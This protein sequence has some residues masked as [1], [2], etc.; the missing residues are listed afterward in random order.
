LAS[1]SLLIEGS[2]SARPRLLVQG[3]VRC[4]HVVRRRR[5]R[6]RGVVEAADVIDDDAGRVVF[7]ADRLD[8][9]ARLLHL[10]F[11][12]TINP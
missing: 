12:N 4:R 3:G 10:G 8:N 5:R 1:F 9:E 6:R 2:H 7:N 11:K